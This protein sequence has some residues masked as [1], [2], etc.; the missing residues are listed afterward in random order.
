MPGCP[1]TRSKCATS[2]AATRSGRS[3]VGKRLALRFLLVFGQAEG[4][5]DFADDVFDGLHR[6]VAQ[7][8]LPWIG[9]VEI[10]QLADVAVDAV[11]LGDD[12]AV[13]SLEL[14]AE[15]LLDLRR[16][17]DQVS[18]ERFGQHGAH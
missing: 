9:W 3:A 12:C 15:G 14:L 13:D 7:R 8:S 18:G 6:L 11:R 10:R 17:R 5:G 1:L 4:G 2:L 16:A